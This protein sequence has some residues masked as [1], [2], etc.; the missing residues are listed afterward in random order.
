MLAANDLP[1]TLADT[2]DTDATRDTFLRSDAADADDPE[3]AAPSPTLRVYE[4]TDAADAPEACAVDKGAPV[5]EEEDP[6]TCAVPRFDNLVRYADDDAVAALV[7]A[8]STVPA[9]LAPEPDT[10]LACSG[11][12]TVADAAEEDTTVLANACRSVSRATVETDADTPD[13]AVPSRAVPVRLALAPAAADAC[14]ATNLVRFADTVDTDAN[15]LACNSVPVRL[16]LAPDSAYERT[17][18]RL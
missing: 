12:F 5:R 6:E 11:S 1:L 8:V 14:N 10:A 2:P 4:D 13:R 9:R 16:A 7:A 18:R 15:T 3:G 17:T